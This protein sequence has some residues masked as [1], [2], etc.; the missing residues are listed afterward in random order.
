MKKIISFLSLALTAITLLAQTSVT[1]DG[2]KYNLDDETKT[3]T[4]T[5]PNE[6]KPN[7]GDNCSPYT[8]DVTIPA[9]VTVEDVTYSVTGIGDYAFRSAKITSLTLPESLVS[10]G[11]KAIYNTQ[12]TELTLPGNATD[13][14]QYAMAYNGSLTKVTFG[15]N[16]ATKAWGEWILYRESPEYDIYMDCHAKP[17]VPDKYTFDHGYASRIHVYPD[18]YEAYVND[19]YWGGKYTIMPDMGSGLELKDFIVD[20]IKYKMTAEDKV[21]VTYPTEGKPGS[22]NPNTYTG[23]FVI[24]AQV[25]YEGKTYAVTGIG[26]YAFRYADITS[27][28]MPEGLVSIGEEAIYKTQITEITLPNSLTT[29]G[30]YAVGYNSKLEKITVGSNAAAKEWGKW[31]FWRA[32]GAYEVYMICDTKP[33]V[34]DIYTFDNDFASNIHIYPSLYLDYKTDYH[35][36]CYNIVPD[37]VQEMTHEDLQNA[38]AAY[39]AKLPADEEVGTNP[40]CYTATSVNAV[41]EALAAASALDENATPQQRN[42]ALLQMIIAVDGLAINPLN[43]GYYYIENLYNNKY[44]RTSSDGYIAVKTFDAS[45]ARFCF[46]LT[47]KGSNWY[48]QAADESK[49]YFGTL[50]AEGWVLFSSDPDYEQ[51]I[52]WVSGGIYKMQCLNGEEA[53]GLYGQS[54]GYVYVNDYTDDNVRAQ[55]RFHPVQSGTFAQDFNI[56][57]IRVREYMAEVT[58]EGTEETKIKPYNV[59]PPARRDTPEPATIFWTQN[60]SATAQQ[61]TWSLNPDFSDAFTAEVDLSNA[62]YEIFNL[63]PGQTYYYKVELTVDGTPTEIINSSFTTSGQLRQI[64]AEGT[65]NMRDLGGWATASGKPIKYGLIYRGAEW[66]GEYQLTPEGIAALRAIGLKAELDL[67]IDWESAYITQSPLG[68]DV[69]Y[70]RITNED[71]YESGM[72]NRKDLYLQD[73]QFVFDCV[74]N[75]KPVYFHCHIG[76]DRTGTLAVILEGLLGVGLSDLYKDYELTT[77]SYYETHRYKENIDGI[78]EYI[79]SLDGET[80]TDKFYTYCHTELGLSAKEIAD[81]RQKMLGVIYPTD[82]KNV[83]AEA[84]TGKATSLDL[85]VYEFQPDVLPFGMLAGTNLLITVAPESG[86]FGQNIISDG[87]CENLVLTDGAD[88]G[89]PYAFTAKEVKFTTNVNAYKTLVLPFEANVPEGFAAAKAASVTGNLVNL[90]EAATISAGEPVLVQ[91]TGEFQLTTSNA[92]IAASDEAVLENGLFVGTYKNIPAPVGSY[93]LQNQNGV[94]GFYQVAEVQPTVGAFRAW[95]NAP[96]S[97]VKAFF[98]GDGATSINEE[99]RMKNEEL[100]GA[101]YNLAG[102]RINKMQKGINIVNGNKILK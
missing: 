91:G 85:S 68:E 31:V 18:V 79:N 15:E 39:S 23:D 69:I 93:V 7:D 80:L 55:W 8:G 83:V 63:L 71:Y 64:Y 100:E 65:G 90:E 21:S 59:A 74:K 30:T 98:F 102:Q 73:L 94:T 27:I 36:N 5:Y 4:V 47:H 81:F 50:D 46:K 78:L 6:T 17:T 44:I 84:V 52:T 22:S 37:L 77:F 76:A 13:F 61:V 75:D 57:N 16:C 34:P 49:Q 56:E 1:V 48:I 87:V 86:I 14:G 88:F 25:T 58:Y 10:I 40:G 89:A 101:M 95:L 67:R 96:A 28:T 42:E 38:I 12:I 82:V 54:S 43:E 29:T 24:P 35:W 62:H 41:K 11:Q 3:A 33:E 66:N 92:A 97:S 32:S 45:D 70:K 2:I 51:I 20:G 60:A 99:L 26:N 9:Q 19:P 72:Q 53:S